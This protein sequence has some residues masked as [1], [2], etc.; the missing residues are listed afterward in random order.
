LSKR[1]GYIRNVENYQ[2]VMRNDMARHVIDVPKEANTA[3]LMYYAI[4]H[5]HNGTSG[6]GDCEIKPIQIDWEDFTDLMPMSKRNCALA[7]QKA[8]GVTVTF[9]DEDTDKRITEVIFTT[10]IWKAGKITLLINQR[11]APYLLNLSEKFASASLKMLMR[12]SGPH[13]RA[14]FWYLTMQDNRIRKRVGI[15][16]D[17]MVDICRLPKSKANIYE[18][19]K[20][21]KALNDDESTFSGVKYDEIYETL[22][23]KRRTKI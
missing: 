17:D 5:I 13:Q 10:S 23:W 20:V 22:I 21:V 4:S 14:L 18:V 3:A 9:T 1:K 8:V 12:L 2:V 7:V 11:L 15:T 16:L 6:D 19:Q